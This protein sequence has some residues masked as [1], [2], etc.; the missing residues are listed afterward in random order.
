[1]WFLLAR[2][3]GPE[4]LWMAEEIKRV[5]F[6]GASVR[7]LFD[8]CEETFPPRVTQ[9]VL[10]DA[11]LHLDHASLRQAGAGYQPSKNLPL[12]GGDGMAAPL[13]L[14]SGVILG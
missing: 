13:G 8:G 14:Q 2:M 1:M 12:R 7:V 3:V 10:T 6:L 4:K 9:T 11:A 5:E